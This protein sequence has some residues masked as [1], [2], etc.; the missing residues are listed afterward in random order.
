MFEQLFYKDFVSQVPELTLLD[1]KLKIRRQEMFSSETKKN[2]ETELFRDLMEFCCPTTQFTLL[3][4][5]QI[6]LDI[7]KIF[8]E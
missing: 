7:G 8:F 4:T 3:D 2:C 5:L 6:N 1:S